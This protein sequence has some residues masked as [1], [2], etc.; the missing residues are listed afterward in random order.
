MSTRTDG[1]MTGPFGR[2]FHRVYSLLDVLAEM[3]QAWERTHN[4]NKIFVR[5]FL[6]RYIFFFRIARPSWQGRL[7]Q[8]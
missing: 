4:G 1:L 6:R 8:W 7:A 2:Q 5:D 3:P